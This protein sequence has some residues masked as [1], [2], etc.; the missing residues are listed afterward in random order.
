MIPAEFHNHISLIKKLYD[1]AMD[2]LCEQYQITRME[3][4]I[5]VFLANN[6]GYDTARDIVEVRQFTKSHV[7]SAIH[8]LEEKKYL[9][10]AYHEGNQKSIHLKLLPASEEIIAAGQAAQRQFFSRIFDG[11]SPEDLKRVESVF[12]KINSNMRLLLKEV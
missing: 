2:P 9:S 1:Q 5:L 4:D 7:S 3:L 8:L 10:R 11:L 6:P 12:C